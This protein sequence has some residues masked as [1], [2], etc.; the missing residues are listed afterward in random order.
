MVTIRNLVEYFNGYCSLV[1]EEKLATATAIALYGSGQNVLLHGP[2]SAGKTKIAESV[3]S[4][5]VP[6]DIDADNLF[7]NPEKLLDDGGVFRYE[8]SSDKAIAYSEDDL[9]R[10]K[11]LFIPELQKVAKQDFILEVLKTMTEGRTAYRDVTQPGGGT[12]RQTMKHSQVLSC[13]ASENPFKVSEDVE[14]QNRLLTLHVDDSAEQTKKVMMEKA[15]SFFTKDNKNN[16]IDLAL[17]VKEHVRT[18]WEHH[19]VPIINPYGI[20]IVQNYL[21]EKYV[22]SRRFVDYYL[23]VMAGVTRWNAVNDERLRVEDDDGELLGYV[24]EIE[25]VYLTE[26]LIGSTIR[27]SMLKLPP[28]SQHIFRLFQKCEDPEKETEY[29]TLNHKWYDDQHG[30]VMLPTTIVMQQLGEMGITLSLPAVTEILETMSQYGY[31]QTE[32]G[33]VS[34]FGLV[35]TAN[36]NAS[37]VDYAETLQA[38]RRL[39]KSE[40]PE[41]YSAWDSRQSMTVTSPLTGSSVKLEEVGGGSKQIQKNKQKIVQDQPTGLEKF[42]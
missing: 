20:P 27:A 21:P 18:L 9:D 4:L 40:Y 22:L 23:A 16:Y 26:E 37:V 19:D 25:D 24:S 17:D 28:Q 42:M 34:R 2:S 39:V 33:R 32:P 5:S 8:F 11:L 13:I 1:G 3:L 14:L 35:S 7:N 6:Y 29:A 12:K 30:R 36:P 38:A 10:A 41:V 31:L 15:R